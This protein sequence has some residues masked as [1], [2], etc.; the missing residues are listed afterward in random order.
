MMIRENKLIKC[1]FKGLLADE[2]FNNKFRIKSF[3]VSDN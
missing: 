1:E 2:D 3:G